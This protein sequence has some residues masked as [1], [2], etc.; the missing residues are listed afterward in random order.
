MCA[1]TSLNFYTGVN[2]LRSPA[3]SMVSSDSSQFSDMLE[4]TVNI[5]LSVTSTGGTE[6][7]MCVWGGG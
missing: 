5:Q 1:R 7:V 3:D 2:V 6:F 4:P